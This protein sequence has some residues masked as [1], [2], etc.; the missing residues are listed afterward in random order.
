[1]TSIRPKTS[2]TATTPR[3]WR[4]ALALSLVAFATGA[5]AKGE[6]NKEQH[7][8]R[9]NDYLAAQQYGQ[10]EKEYREVLRLA[11]EDPAALRQLGMIYFEQQQIRQ[12]YPLLKKA[13]ELQPE[14]L[15]LQLK[16]GTTLL[17]GGDREQA[18]DAALQVLEK[19]PGQEQALLLLADASAKT[20]GY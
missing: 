4:L 19:Q 8:S 3:F 10:A 16:L 13:A 20:R 7:L 11:P 9:A 1:M 6:E 17:L 2:Q 5:C 12:A 18:R 15:E 14:D